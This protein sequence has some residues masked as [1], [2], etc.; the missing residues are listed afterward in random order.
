MLEYSVEFCRRL[1]GFLVGNLIGSH[2]Q[3]CDSIKAA[4]VAI[5]GCVCCRT[6]TTTPVAM[7][8]CDRLGSI[9]DLFGIVLG[10][11]SGGGG[12]CCIS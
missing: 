4:L 2:L 7:V 12:G 6:V 1:L 8:I 5:V 11:V 10:F 3:F 9:D